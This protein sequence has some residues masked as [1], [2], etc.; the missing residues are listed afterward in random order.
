MP[1]SVAALLGGT[2]YWFLVLHGRSPFGVGIW[3]IKKQIIDYLG[4]EIPS[5]N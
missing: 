4:S 2:Y 5:A 3:A 1:P